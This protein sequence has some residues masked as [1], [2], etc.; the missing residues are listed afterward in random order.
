MMSRGRSYMCVI[1][2]N[3]DGMSMTK[4]DMQRAMLAH[5]P[6]IVEPKRTERAKI[7]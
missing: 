7:K 3:R 2:V 5:F 6:K 4:K 1:G